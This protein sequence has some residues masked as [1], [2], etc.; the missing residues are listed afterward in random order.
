MPLIESKVGKQGIR[1]TFQSSIPTNFSNTYASSDV[2]KRASWQSVKA[3]WRTVASGRA[4]QRIAAYLATIPTK[5]RM[6]L[7]FNH[8]PENDGKPSADFRAASRRFY[9][10]VKEH[11]PQTLV[12]PILMDW[13]FDPASGLHPADWFPGS[14]YC[15]FIG[16]D[17]YQTYLFPPAGSSKVWKSSTTDRQKAAVAWI[18]QQ[19]CLPA[20]GEF[21]CG[22]WRGH[23]GKAA[24]DFRRKVDWV[25][26]TLEFFE[27]AGAVAACYFNTLIN[28]DLAPKPLLQDD[29]LTTSYWSGVS[30][31]H[32]KAI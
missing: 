27:S 2:G 10:V 29:S 25:K 1:R 32:P 20:I 6:L 12:G 4:D 30:A 9:Q 26:S 28:N 21:A 18:H 17:T 14:A 31:S 15:D 5:H 7:T 19:G 3:D 13:T 11:R 8:E 23:S 22:P 24:D 16:I